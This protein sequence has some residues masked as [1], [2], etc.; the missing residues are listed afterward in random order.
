MTKKWYNTNPKESKS[1]FEIWKN[2]KFQFLTCSDVYL[3]QF[4]WFLQ[5]C[6]RISPRYFA[7]NSRKHRVIIMQP[8][9]GSTDYLSFDLQKH[10]FY[11]SEMRAESRPTKICLHHHQGFSLATVQTFHALARGIFLSVWICQ[12]NTT[13]LCGKGT[14]SKTTSKHQMAINKNSL[15]LLPTTESGKTFSFSIFHAFTI[16][17]IQKYQ[18][19]AI[20][21]YMS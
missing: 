12:T 2:G 9:F 11:L 10:R 1:A 7:Q 20:R 3:E 6:S 15:Y 16:E 8:P 21:W 5:M 4:V 18:T 13:T 17:K 19:K 14:E